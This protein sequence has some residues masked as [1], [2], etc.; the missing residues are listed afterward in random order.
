MRFSIEELFL[1][2]GQFDKVV[3]LCFNEN[4]KA[5]KDFN[6]TLTGVFVYT[7]KERENLQN[8]IKLETVPR[9]DGYTKFEELINDVNTAQKKDLLTKGILA[10]D[11]S[12]VFHMQHDKKNEYSSKLIR[13]LPEPIKLEVDF[14]DVDT[15]AF[16]LGCYN[17]LESNGVRLCHF[18]EDLCNSIRLK[19]NNG[20]VPEG[21]EDKFI[22]KET[23]QIYTGIKYQ[24]LK[25]NILNLT[26]SEREELSTIIKDRT[27]ARVSLLMEEFKRTTDNLKDTLALN[28]SNVLKFVSMAGFFEPIRLLVIKQ[29]LWLDFDRLIHIFNRHVNEIKVGERTAN[30]TSFQYKIDD[31][32]RLIKLVLESIHDEIEQHYIDFPN[33]PFKR[34]GE[35]SVFYHGDYYVIGINEDGKLM[36]FYKKES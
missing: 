14:S 21:L 15:D 28:Q 20:K 29:P 9:N 4:S 3:T 18:E 13:E 30:K 5:F 26:D 16:T 31:I 24:Y 34:Q 25:D 11:I 22:D 6:E 12:T 7:F 27:N 35:M 33:K 36:D 17:M 8:Q 1:N 19:R 2:F 32:I 23:G 10:S